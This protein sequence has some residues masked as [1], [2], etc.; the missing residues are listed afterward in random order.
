[1]AP[2][3][4]KC[5]GVGRKQRFFARRLNLGEELNEGKPWF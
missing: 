1:M 5:S 4:H 2:A 3:C